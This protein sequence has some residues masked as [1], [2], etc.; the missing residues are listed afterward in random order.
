MAGVNDDDDAVLGATSCD[1]DAGAP[2]VLKQLKRQDAT[3]DA[4]AVASNDAWPFLSLSLPL[5]CPSTC[6]HEANSLALPLPLE[7]VYLSHPIVLRSSFDG[8]R[9]TNNTHV[10]RTQAHD[11]HAHSTHVNDTHAIGNIDNMTARST[12]SVSTSSPLST[13]SRSAVESKDQNHGKRGSVV[14]TRRQRLRQLSRGQGLGQGHGREP[15]LKPWQGLS[16]KHT[17]A[18]EHTLTATP[19]SIQT[20]VAD[21]EDVMVTDIDIDALADLRIRAKP[22]RCNNATIT[23][24]HPCTDDQYIT[25]QCNT[26]TLHTT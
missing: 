7:E 19:A 16:Q 5:S 23:L 24:Q 3:D 20:D 11:T 13:S 21:G 12:A 2:A 6:S 8:V 17:H 1:A 22:G 4:D 14:L 15:A 26:S 10:N 9:D 18:H 25:T